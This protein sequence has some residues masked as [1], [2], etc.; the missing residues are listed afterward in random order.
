MTVTV[1]FLS[2]SHLY[3]ENF[4]TTQ[5]FKLHSLTKPFTMHCNVNATLKTEKKNMSPLNGENV[6]AERD[7][8]LNK[9]VSAAINEAVEVDGMELREC[10]AVIFGIIQGKYEILNNAKAVQ[11]I[12]DAHLIFMDGLS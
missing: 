8:K 6:M 10:M 7:D 2:T 12:E 3:L 9:V 11:A 4:K 1:T 5:F